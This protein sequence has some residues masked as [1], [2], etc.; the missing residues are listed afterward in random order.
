MRLL[1]LFCVGAALASPALKSGNDAFWK[2]DFVGAARHY[3]ALTRTNPYSA[4]AWYNLGC[5]Q[6]EAG[7]LGAAIHAFEQA[8]LLRPDDEDARHNLE[9]SRA[10]AVRKGLEAN[11][12]ARVILPGDDDVGTGLLT[13]FSPQ[14]LAL[15]FSLGWALLF[16]G[17]VVWRRSERSGRR[18]ALAFASLVLALFCTATGGLLLG[19][20]TVVDRTRF[21]VVVGTQAGVH[22][23][24][25]D[26]YKPQAVVLG[27][28]KLRVRGVDRDWSHVRLPDGSEGWLRST[29]LR[30][31]LRP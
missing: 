2:E 29:D 20:A 7:A 31:L 15:A 24:P 30:E 13:A 5:A 28:V 10:E 4:D 8:L 11:T 22:T 26:Q 1:L 16:L 18:T 23:G 19:R 17:L 21:G 14:P 9:Q 25:G 6:A 3:E 27:G 12:N